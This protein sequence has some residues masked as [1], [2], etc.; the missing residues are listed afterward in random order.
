MVKLLLHQLEDGEIYLV[1]FQI[2]GAHEAYLL[3]S[4]GGWH[5]ARSKARLLYHSYEQILGFGNVQW[6]ERP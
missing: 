5:V 1:V 2:D 3:G 4:A 6:E